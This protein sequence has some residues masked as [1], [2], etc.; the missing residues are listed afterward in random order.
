V[1][2]KGFEDTALYRFNR[3][4]SLNDVGGDPSRFGVTLAEFHAENTARASRSPTPVGHGHP[5]HKRGEDHRARIKRAVRDPRRVAAPRH[6][7]AAP[8][9]PSSRDGRRA[10]VPGANTST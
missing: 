8:Q 4:V 3:L 9:P 2:A 6:P 5:R 10:R 1:T 7:L